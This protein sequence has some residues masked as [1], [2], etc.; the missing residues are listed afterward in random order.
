[1]SSGDDISSESYANMNARVDMDANKKHLRDEFCAF[2]DAI[3]NNSKNAGMFG[4]DLAQ[5][6]EGGGTGVGGKGTTDEGAGKEHRA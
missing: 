3:P 4:V 1:M 2:C 6:V 5:E